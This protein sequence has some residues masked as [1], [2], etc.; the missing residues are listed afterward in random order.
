MKLAILLNL[1]FQQFKLGKY[2]CNL[3]FLIF[4]LF[5]EVSLTYNIILFAG[6]QYND[7]IFVC[8]AK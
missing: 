8:V 5:I 6:I 7:L 1:C 2:L 4:K 3:T